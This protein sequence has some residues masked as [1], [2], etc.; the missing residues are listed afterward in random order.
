MYAR[1]FELLAFSSSIRN[2]LARRFAVFFDRDV[3]LFPTPVSRFAIIS[4]AYTIYISPQ[5]TIMLLVLF[6][7]PVLASQEWEY[8]RHGSPQTVFVLPLVHA[9]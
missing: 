2:F 8:S 3:L 9:W 7:I 6:V 1:D 4:V 5:E